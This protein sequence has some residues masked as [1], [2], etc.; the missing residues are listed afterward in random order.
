M[1][2]GKLRI[3]VKGADAVTVPVQLA[4]TVPDMQELA[5]ENIGVIVRCFNRGFRIENQE[6][7]GARDTFR[8]LFTQGK[9]AEEIQAACAKK[10]ED[11]DPTAVVERV[12]RPKKPVKIRAAKGK[13]SFSQEELLDLLAKA[14]VTATFE[15]EDEEGAASLD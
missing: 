2:V 13:K 9:P 1:E 7:S 15:D 12:G 4:E 14:G 3:G 11:Y 6:R 8:E 5:Q 10:V